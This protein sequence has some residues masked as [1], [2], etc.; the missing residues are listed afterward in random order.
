[1]QEMD[2]AV[3]EKVPSSAVALLLLSPLLGWVT[4]SV[5]RR[6][7]SDALAFPLMA[8]FV[9]AASYVPEVAND[10]SLVFL[11]IAIVGSWSRKDPW[12]VHLGLASA[13]VCYQPLTLPISGFVLLGVKLAALA[14]AGGSLVR[15][16]R[17]LGSIHAAAVARGAAGSA[18]SAST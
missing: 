1:M 15:R 9:A 6:P 16:A 18:P 11:P 17:E 5:Y 12:L 2:I 8:W 3:P 14:A 10:Y 13:L 7:G 4:V